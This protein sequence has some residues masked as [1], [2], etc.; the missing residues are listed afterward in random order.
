MDVYAEIK[1]IKYSP[2]NTPKLEEQKFDLFEINTCPSN[3]F[4]S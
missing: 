2:N 4:V 1:G 3:C